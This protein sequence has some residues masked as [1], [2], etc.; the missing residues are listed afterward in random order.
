[1][2][3]IPTILPVGTVLPMA[4]RIRWYD[5]LTDD[6]YDDGKPHTLKQNYPWIGSKFLSAVI[7][8]AALI[9]GTA[10]CRLFL[11]THYKNAKILR[12]EKGSFFLY[13]NHT[14]PV[15]D[16][17]LPALA[18]FPKRIYT[19]VSPAN[20]DLPV[21]GKILPWLGALPTAED[22]SGMKKLLSTMD[23]RLSRGN[24]IVVYPEA[25]VWDYCTMI[26]PFS[27]TS[28]KLP[29]RFDKPVYVMSVT[30]Q[31][32]CFGKR[33]KTTVYLDGPV[34]PEGKTDKEKAAALQ[35]AVAQIMQRRSENSTYAYIDYKQR[36]T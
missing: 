23:Y 18:A 3:L 28:F 24:P 17:F 36:A 11:H 2:P 25:H 10:Y 8:T 13:G 15:G 21:I 30:Y 16:V 35:T 22:L 1:M 14:Q 31:K 4:D 33:P 34:R 27:A 19:V 26:R 9:F 32:R 7:Y 6:F 12:K 5:A 29:V 20:L